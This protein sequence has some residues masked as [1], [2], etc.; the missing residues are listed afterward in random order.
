M[1]DTYL[2]F[3]HHDIVLVYLLIYVDDIIVM[4][5]STN[6]MS[7]ILASLACHFFIKDPSELNYFLEIKVSR[8][9]NGLHMMQRKYIVDLLTNTNMLQAKPVSIPMAASLKL[10]MH[11]R[12]LLYDPTEYRTVVGNLQYSAFT[13]LDIAYAINRLS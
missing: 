7:H 8:T 2:F 4:G 11:S 12:E 1:A 6:L 5:N 10:T 9:S 3:Y 13:R